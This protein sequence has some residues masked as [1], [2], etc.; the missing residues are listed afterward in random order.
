MGR[1]ESIAGEVFSTKGAG[2]GH[3]GLAGE[4]LSM[5]G[6]GQGGGLAKLVQSFEGHGLGS[7]VQ[8]WI[9][10][11]GNLPI[12]ADQIA[13]VL[14]SGRISQLAAKFGIAP[15]DVSSHV[16]RILPGLVDAL[17]P[18]GSIPESDMLQEGLSVL[19]QRLG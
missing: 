7:V 10:R 9:A 5:L 3:P 6:G 19:R 8:S 12:S 11:G 17:T 4:L 14:G 18:N 16:S 2:F 15:E 1:F 13:T